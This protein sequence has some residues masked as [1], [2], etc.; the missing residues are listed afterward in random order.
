MNKN[1]KLTAAF[2]A[3][4]VVLLAVYFLS[5]PPATT[6]MAKLDDHVLTGLSAEQ[7]SKIE[8]TRQDGVSMTFEKAT[9]VVGEYW[10]I[11][12]QSGHAAE[13]AMVQQLLF[14]LDR[15]V[16]MGGLDA[17]TPQTAPELTGL[18]DPRLIVTYS[19]AGRREMLRFGKQPPTNTT[20]VFFQHEG[21]PKVYLVG[22]ETFDSFMKPS[23]QYRAKNL[24]RFMPNKV[25]KVA[26]EYKF[27][28]PQ[29]KGKPDVVEYEKS[30]LERFEEGAERG[31]YLTSPHKERMDDHAVA[32][33]VTRMSDL[34][35]SDYQPAEPQKEKG[36]DEPQVKITL[37]FY[38]QDKPMEVRFG[39]PAERDRKRWV[40]AAGSAEA[41]LLDA[42]HYEDIPLQRSAM[43]IRRIF[44]FSPEL[45][46]RLEI[47][48]KDL[49]KVVLERKEV[50]KEGDPV[51]TWKWE[52]VE[53]TN[54]KVESERLE[55]FVAAVVVQDIVEFHGDQDFQ[56]VGLDAAPVTL[57][58]D[59]KEGNRHVCWFS[60]K[61]HGYLRK[62][63]VNE[64]F[65]VRSDLVKML[66]R[67]ELNFVSLEMYNV[68]REG[69]REI[70]F[71][72]KVTTQ[73]QP[74]LYRM[75][76][77]PVTRLWTFSDPVHQGTAPDAA[78][79]SDLLT[80]VNYIK[81]E[82]LLGRDSKT[83]EQ[84]RLDER[85]APATLKLSYDIGQGPAAKSGDMELYISEDQS[86]TAG[87]PL[88]YAR[89]RDN[90]AVFKINGDFVQ[91][92]QKFLLQ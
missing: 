67:L 33:L 41:A 21:D 13:G 45:V 34:Q 20:A 89:L 74:I 18:A 29:G 57:T 75:K 35:C 85:T 3:L 54:I 8:I 7:V 25:N 28:R 11:V 66:Q 32:M 43:R 5:S 91:A 6:P 87:Q 10:R 69:I 52:V 51:S 16:R 71:E 53:P 26:L 58:V 38:Q 90:L 86:T 73:L 27:L 44:P 30:I 82:S 76:M 78:K 88:Y 9:D 2:G 60:V 72:S 24:V 83:I 12:E 62:E 61:A 39:L 14:A 79:L 22:V 63:G 56:L 36:L 65:E 4:L 23:L 68:P 37:H 81:A 1:W 17:G 46:K 50:K 84:Y 40:W 77:D 64:I 55:A 31:W 42:G 15:F 19:S 47:E 59:T 92:L 48:A 49:G 80:R 70:S